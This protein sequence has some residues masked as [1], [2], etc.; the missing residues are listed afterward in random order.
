MPRLHMKR[1]RNFLVNSFNWKID[2]ALY[3]G[4]T[5]MWLRIKKPHTHTNTHVYMKWIFITAFQ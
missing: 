5:N 2:A 3:C 4:M 1:Q